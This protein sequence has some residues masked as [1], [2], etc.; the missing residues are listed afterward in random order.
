MTVNLSKA[1]DMD[2]L[3]QP[4]TDDWYY[5]VLTNN[6]FIFG[7]DWMC[8]VDF[9]E[10][11]YTPAEEPVPITPR[12]ADGAL[13]A[14]IIEELRPYF[15]GYT[16]DVYERRKQSDEYLS[17]C[18][19]LLETVDG[20]IVPSVSPMELTLRMPEEEIVFDSTVP[21]DMQL[22]L[23]SLNRGTLDGYGK[24]IG[25]N[26]TESALI[27]GAY[28][29]QHKGE[30]DGGAG[31]PLLY[32]FTY[33]VSAIQNSHDYAFIRGQLL[34]FEEMEQ[35][36]IYEDGQYVCYNVSDLFYSDLR[37][38]VESMVSQRSDV[39][40]DEQVWE[41]VQNI[42]NYFNENLGTMICYRDTENA[43]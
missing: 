12:E 15:E 41:R 31:I 4:L 24:I 21:L 22:Q 25:A 6:N 29:P 20:N 30:I 1:Y 39:Y 17:L 10:P 23:T 28:I 32:I 33:E 2:T 16:V 34:T 26:D 5:F 9:A 43:E 18:Q 40:F 11:I 7:Q 38:Y 19:Q 37:G 36:K 3:E 35:Y 27:F 42:Y 13:V 14:E 8:S